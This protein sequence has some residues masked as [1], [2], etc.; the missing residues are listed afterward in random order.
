MTRITTFTAACSAA[1]LFATG[2]L[3]AEPLKAS[4]GGYMHIGAG[5]VD[6]ATSA[7]DTKFGVIR[8]GEI[9]FK[10]KGTSDNG[11]TFDGR[12]EL[13]AF[14]SSSDQ[15]DENWARVSGTFGAIMIGGNDQV[16][17][18]MAA[19]VLYA[20]GTKIGYYDDD[21]LQGLSGTLDGTGDDMGIHYQSPSFY[22]F[23]AG[24][25]YIPDV[26]TDGANDGQFSGDGDSAY[27]LAMRYDGGYGDVT[28]AAAGGWINIDTA[29]GAQDTF[30]FGGEGTYS[31]FTLAAYWEQNFDETN[32]YTLGAAYKT[33]PW[34]F[35]GGYA[36]TE[37]D[38][39][40]DTDT[41]AGWA[42]Y[43]LAPGVSTSAGV[44]HADN[45]DTTGYSALAWMSLNF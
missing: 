21:V 33:G 40:P 19:G 2:A 26:N 5:V 1:A 17:T 20:P 12:V 10:F 37:K 31:G 30:S 39:A 3:A 28:Y 11:L 43:A 18:E 15:I 13:E 7:D 42:T 25:S 9:H 38:A 32:D 24:A 27:A 23:S 36:L 35:A 22:G 8:D 45:G 41:F 34:T 29:T 4:V 44:A 6:D 14:T 16:K